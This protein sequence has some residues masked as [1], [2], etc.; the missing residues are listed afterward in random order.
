MSQFF[1]VIRLFTDG[2]RASARYSCRLDTAK[3][4]KWTKFGRNSSEKGE[5]LRK[6]NSATDD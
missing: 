1:T 4:L 2:A 3:A 5:G 6:I